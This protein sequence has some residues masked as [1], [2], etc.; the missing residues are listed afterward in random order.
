ML[1][2]DLNAFLDLYKCGAAVDVKSLL[3]ARLV[4]K[5]PHCLKLAFSK[6]SRIAI[7]KGLNAFMET[8]ALPTGVLHTPHVFAGSKLKVEEWSRLKTNEELNP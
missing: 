5:G 2:Q 7:S 4:V 6:W 8:C 1:N 3:H